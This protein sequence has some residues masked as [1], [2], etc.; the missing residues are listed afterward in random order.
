MIKHRI[1]LEIRGIGVYLRGRLHEG[2]LRVDE[3]G[4]LKTT[5]I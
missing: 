2:Y 5:L 1:S 3:L 4:I